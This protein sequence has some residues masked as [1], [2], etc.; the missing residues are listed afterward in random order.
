MARTGKIELLL[1]PEGRLSGLVETMTNTETF[2]NSLD[3]L[4]Y[5]HIDLMTA[6]P[7]AVTDEKNDDLI[8]HEWEHACGTIR[9]I[10][11]NHLIVY[12]DTRIVYEREG[13]HTSCCRPGAWVMA[14]YDKSIERRNEVEQAELET[15]EKMA[16]DRHIN[17]APVIE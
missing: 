4:I 12:W 10:W 11:D 13:R 3:R 15:A 7:D 14:V 17:F 6:H 2:A 5:P 8:T 1:R 16:R 9:V